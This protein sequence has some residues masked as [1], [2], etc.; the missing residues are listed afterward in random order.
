MLDKNEEI[1]LAKLLSKYPQIIKKAANEYEPSILTR[2]LIDVSTYF[3]RFYNECPVLVD[4]SKLK[5]TRCALVYAVGIV[6]KSGLSVL[7][8]ECPE[9]M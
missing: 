5:I 6:I 2:Y 8:I 7:G 1:E 9:K 4:D 3:S